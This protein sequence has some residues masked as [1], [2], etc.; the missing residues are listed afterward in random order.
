[1]IEAQELMKRIDEEL[2]QLHLV[3]SIDEYKKNPL[4]KRYIQK[5]RSV[6]AKLREVEKCHR[7]KVLE[8]QETKGDFYGGK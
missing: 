1:M 4:V 5:L 7:H 6:L 2:S 8:K 3:V